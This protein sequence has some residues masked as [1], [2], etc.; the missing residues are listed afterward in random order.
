MRYRNNI[1]ISGNIS[2]INTDNEK[3]VWLDIAQNTTYKNKEGNKEEVRYFFNT[4]LFKDTYEKLKDILVV[5]KLVRISGALRNY[6]DKSN[7][8]ISF[9]QVFDIREINLKEDKDVSKK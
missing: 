8:K 1:D 6:Y 2:R 7:N 3:F 4:R 9:I 5:G